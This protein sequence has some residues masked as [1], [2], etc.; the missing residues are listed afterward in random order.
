MTRTSQAH[1]AIH[2]VFM[3]FFSLP[4]ADAAS[5]SAVQAKHKT[6]VAFWEK[7]CEATGNN[8]SESLITAST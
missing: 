7:L 1:K 4:C 3:V 8:E 2:L 5:I 6:V